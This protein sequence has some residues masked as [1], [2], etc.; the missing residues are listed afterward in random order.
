MQNIAFSKGFTLIE[1]TIWIVIITIIALS[2]SQMQFSRLSEKQNLMISLGSFISHYETLRDNA[3]I[4]RFVETLSWDVL[5]A[6]WHLRVENISS[7]WSLRW[8][9]SN[10]EMFSSLVWNIW[11]DWDFK[12]PFAITNIQCR[13]IEDT[14]RLPGLSDVESATIR[15]LPGSISQLRC[16][17]AAYSTHDKILIIEYWSANFSETL[18]INTLTGIIQREPS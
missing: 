2:I 16:S 9:Y 1:L 17:W 7:S 5:P 12:R 6:W 11:L 4:G 10:D 15:F 8:S 14:L 3:L 18:T 13:T